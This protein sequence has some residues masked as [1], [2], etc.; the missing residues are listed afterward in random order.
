MHALAS[1]NHLIGLAQIDREHWTLIAQEEEFSVA[2][3]AG[4]SRAKLE[5]QLTQLIVGFKRHFHAEEALMQSNAFPGLDGHTHE[6][7]EL[8][9]QI[10]G[11]RD[12]LGSG[13]VKLCDAIVG[14]MGLWTEQHIAGP[15]RH[16][17]QFLGEK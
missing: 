1:D 16:F 13:I 6:H 11:L 17:A 12:D 15:D 2:V 7:R 4:A 8:I 10:S 9:G 14:F 5:A 3:N